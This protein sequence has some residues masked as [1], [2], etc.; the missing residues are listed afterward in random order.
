MKDHTK[1]REIGRQI[2]KEGEDLGI[3]MIQTC[4]DM[5]A[6]K[7]YKLTCEHMPWCICIISNQRYVGKS[8]V[9]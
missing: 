9:F 3:K 8:V 4:V 6:S 1:E 7:V 2:G 5:W